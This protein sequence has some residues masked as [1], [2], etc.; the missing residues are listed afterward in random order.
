MERTSDVALTFWW[1]LDI[2][3]L[4]TSSLQHRVLVLRLSVYVTKRDTR[5]KERKRTERE[6]KIVIVSEIKCSRH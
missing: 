4:F 6:K 3:L 2:D 5:T 1:L